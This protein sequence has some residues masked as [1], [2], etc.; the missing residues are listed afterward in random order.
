[1]LH[2]QAQ[3]LHAV[4]AEQKN[5]QLTFS[6]GHARASGLA[7]F[8]EALRKGESGQGWYITLSAA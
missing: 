1:M 3:A 5:M 7:S 2:D 6:K 4:A 8:T